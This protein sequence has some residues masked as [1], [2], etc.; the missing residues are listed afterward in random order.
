LAP[1]S[2]LKNQEWDS[3]RD[4]PE[5]SQFLASLACRS[6]ADPYVAKGV[7]RRVLADWQDRHLS[8]AP[9]FAKALRDPSCVGAHDF[10]KDLTTSLDQLIKRADSQ[11]A[12]N[13]PDPGSAKQEAPASDPQQQ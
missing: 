11:N 9:I 2:K 5:L 4:D 13:A 6:D 1:W 8:Y 3:K 7:A 12:A 10:S